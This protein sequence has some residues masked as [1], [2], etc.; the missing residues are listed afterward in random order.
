MSSNPPCENGTLGGE[1]FCITCLRAIGDRQQVRA[2]SYAEVIYSLRA[3]CERALGYIG[4]E[5]P[6][7]SARVCL[8]ALEESAAVLA[9]WP[10]EED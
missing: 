10:D 8:E 5:N 2:E 4:E 1:Q 6:D 7:K 3:A 9:K